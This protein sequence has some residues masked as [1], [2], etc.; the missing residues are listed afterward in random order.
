M[1]SDC[2]PELPNECRQHGLRQRDRVLIQAILQRAVPATRGVS[3]GGSGGGGS[4]VGGS[5]AA[6]TTPAYD[7]LPCDILTKRLPKPPCPRATEPD[8][9]GAP[10]FAP[11]SKAGAKGSKAKGTV[12]ASDSSSSSRRRRGRDSSKDS[13]TR[14]LNG[15]P[16]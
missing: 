1:A 9:V 11:K 6:S 12:K 10:W 14:T 5:S 15:I 4:S 8:A 2:D 13:K 7:D 16:V 3:G